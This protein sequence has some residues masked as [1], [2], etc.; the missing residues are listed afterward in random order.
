MRRA[1]RKGFTIVELL[2]VI[3][4]ISILMTLV[5]SGVTGAM[6]DAR[7]RQA[8]ALCQAVQSGLTAYYAQKQEW[9]GNLGKRVENGDFPGKDPNTY[10]LTASEV[11]EMVKELVDEAKKGNPL[12]DISGLIVSTDPGEPGGKGYGLD[13]ISA[14]RGT[15]K[16]GRKMT[17]SSMYFGYLDK[18]TARFRR[19]KMVYS[20]PTDMISVSTQ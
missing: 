7:A 17:T 10:E 8:A 12:M 20:I 14:V 4:V 3:A 6:A 13:F 2:V 16:S 5:F 11:R 19:F 15:R 18:D 9:P 1:M